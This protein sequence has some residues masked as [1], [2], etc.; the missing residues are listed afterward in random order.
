MDL[1]L[2]LGIGL[3][4]S[5]ACGFRVFVPL[6]VM[7][8]AANAGHLTLASSFSWIGSPEALVAF[9]IATAL[10]VGAY[11]VPWLDNFLDTVTTPAA[12]VA[13][14]IATASMLTDM[15]P[16]MKW[17]VAIIAGGGIAGTVQV[18]TVLARGFSLFSTGGVGN[19]LLATVELGGSAATAV[20]AV[21]APFMA[22]GLALLVGGLL[23]YKAVTRK[24][25]AAEVAAPPILA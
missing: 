5:A 16:L 14:S 20:L 3:G 15:S 23:I 25:A 1:L 24:K 22:L 6:L 11:Y 9:S 10:E 18:G 19:P 4:L 13:G 12:V 21:V 8:I 7:S 17:S 2:S